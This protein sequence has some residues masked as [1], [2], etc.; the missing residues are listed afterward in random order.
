MLKLSPKRYS[1]VCY[2]IGYYIGAELTYISPS[3]INY[4]IL[5]LT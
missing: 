3:L 2:V 1:F 5:V 4:E